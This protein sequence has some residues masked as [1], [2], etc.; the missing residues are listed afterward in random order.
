M[1][2]SRSVL[3]GKVSSWCTEREAKELES[4]GYTVGYNA[5]YLLGKDRAPGYYVWYPGATLGPPT[6]TKFRADPGGGTLTKDM[7][8]FDDLLTAARY[9]IVEVSNGA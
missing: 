9:L 1:A 4:M 3:G 5:A 7:V 6:D 8:E 2:T